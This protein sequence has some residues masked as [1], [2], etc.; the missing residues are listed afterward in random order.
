MNTSPHL[1]FAFPHLFLFPP[2]PPFP[3]PLPFSHRYPISSEAALLALLEALNNHPAL[4]KEGGWANIS[5]ML[6]YNESKPCVQFWRFISCD[7]D[8]R[9]NA[10]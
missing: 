5:T 1:G 4:S 10:M 8:G 7:N 6:T 2:I 3:P 9:I